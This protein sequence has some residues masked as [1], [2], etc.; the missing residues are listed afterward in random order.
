MKKSTE[1]QNEHDL[2]QIAKQL[3]GLSRKIPIYLY[4]EA[5]VNDVFSEEARSALSVLSSVTE[6]IT[7]HEHGLNDP[8]AEKWNVVHSPTLLFHP[9]RYRIKWIG[10][11]LGEEWR[12]IIE[13]LV[14]L[15]N[16]NGLYDREA[17]R[18][19][20]RIQTPRNLKVFVSGSCLYCPQ[21]ALNA[22]KAA[23]HKPELISLSIIDTKANQKLAA[24]YKAHSVPRTYVDDLLIA[25]GAQPEELFLLSVE[26]KSQQ[27][28]SLP[29]K[30]E[31]EVDTDL[32]IVGAGPAGL[33]AGIYAARS[34]LGTVVLEKGVL[35]GQVATT[36]VVENYP[37]MKQIGGQALVDIMVMH[38]QE[39][40]RIFQG[41][42]VIEVLPGPPLTVRTDRRSFKAN[43]VLL[44]TGAVNK[45]LDVP[46]ESRLGG[47]GVSYCSTCDGFFFRG[48]KVIM[49]GGGDSAATEAL[50]L[51]NIDVDVTVVHRKDSLKA[52]D[53]LVQQLHQNN[54]PILYNTEVMEIRG[55][56]SVEE[57]LLMNNRTKERTTLD[58]Q[59]V[60]LA[61]GYNPAVEL[62]R[63]A[64]LTLTDEGYIQ[65]E[66]YRTTVP[67]IYTAGDVSGGFKQIVIAAGQGA[68]AASAS[69]I[70]RDLVNPYWKTERGNHYWHPDAIHIYC[71]G[72]EL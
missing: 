65:Q 53:V 70:F 5:G 58:V 44:A 15:G 37:G 32:V 9:E 30:G 10:A 20:D 4:S 2:K 24:R 25:K 36:P 7:V 41:E 67:G 38:A 1:T 22:L 8:S 63:K 59:G 42:E 68:E 69:G 47:R 49:I 27:T 52:Q 57:V 40:V 66:N 64:G 61:I 48:Q 19:L 45:R 60:F 62:A 46:G 21:Q 54:I 12:I 55:K 71:R 33:S 16:G 72:Y 28:S 17:A 18:I 23:I 34:G 50:H 11:P 51:N 29:E 39:Y 26:K 43:A 31:S 13:T 3:K 6:M 35:G 56:H 14:L